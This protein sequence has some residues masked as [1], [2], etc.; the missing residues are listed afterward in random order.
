MISEKRRLLLLA[1][2]SVVACLMV[3]TIII[4]MTYRADV[5]QTFLRLQDTVTSQAR[6]IEAVARYDIEHRRGREPADQTL[7]QVIDAFRNFTGLGDTGEFALARRV[8]NQIV[9][10]YQQRVGASQSPTSI[11]MDA[12][13]AEPMRRALQGKSGT[14]IAVDYRGEMVLAAFEPVGVLHLGLV[15][16]IDRDEIRGAY[17]PAALSAVSIAALVGML[18]IV[19]FL[20]L[21]EPIVKLLLGQKAGLEAIVR[22]HE[23][24]AKRLGHSEAQQ[25]AIAQ[26]GA[27]AL[28]GA[29]IDELF[30]E[31]LSL[32][33]DVLGLAFAS[34][35][36][37]QP[38]K[39]TLL[40]RAGIGWKSGSVGR[41]TV[42]VNGDSQ[43]AHTL[44]PPVSASAGDLLQ[45]N[46]FAASPLMA[47]H[48]L[49]STAS[50]TI[51]G[52]DGPWGVFAVYGKQAGDF[53]EMDVLFVQSLANLLASAINRLRFD[54]DL[55][56]WVVLFHQA[57][58]GIA[59]TNAAGD[60]LTAVNPAFAKMHGY[61]MAEALQVPTR[62]YY[63]DGVELI[64][65]KITQH[66]GGGTVESMRARKDGSVFPAL[67]NVTTVYDDQGSV[68][69][70]V[71][72]V[73]DN[74]ERKQ[75]EES[76]L[77]LER[78]AQNA[79]RFESLG[80]LAGGI[81]HDFNNILMTILGN[82]DLALLDL[83]PQAPV[84]TSIEA[85]ETAA[86]QAV[87]LARQMLAYSGR[88][89]FVVQNIAINSLL[90]ETAHLLEA[91]VSQGIVLKY[92]LGDNLP[93]ISADATQMNQILMNLIINAS[94]AI[95]DKPGV[96][97]VTTG[98]LQCDREYLNSVAM[99][100]QVGI[101][102]ALAEGPYTWI[103]VSDTGCGMSVATLK[104]IFDPFFTTKGAG[105]G[106]G[107]AAI[108]GIVRAHKGA[109][110]VDSEVGK[111]SSVKV[112][113]PA[114]S[115]PAV[116]ADQTAGKVTCTGQ[117][118]ADGTVLLA[119]DDES[120]VALG[121][122]TLKRLG[123]DTI[124]VSDG[125]SAVEAFREHAT[126]ID[127]VI[128]DLTMPQMNGAEAFRE[129]RRIN[130]DAK[131]IL[132]SGYDEVEVTRKFAGEGLN[133]FLHK[134][135]TLDDL[136]RTLLAALD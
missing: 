41:A 68:L 70:Q 30:T 72:N 82:T 134:P 20:R 104:R 23:R 69:C 109:V 2:I 105:R 101:D 135:Y 121:Q 95:G 24:T 13:W 129:I 35:L 122:R 86:R 18:S 116:V 97:Q 132:C 39:Q 53:G 91:S 11:A 127:C 93:P 96:I 118:P 71:A 107:M 92:S 131:V 126:E 76:R 38:D 44:R 113:L 67:Q 81:A 15:A 85:I 110:K 108:L 47:E 124:A 17:I 56:H 77:E 106:L 45:E 84:R 54:E 123:F 29:S 27:L 28:R 63:Q 65:V 120:I 7:G 125:A 79:H 26:L 5:A 33:A 80:V 133:G 50:A 90:D 48:G 59:I 14:I 83:P 36:E 58:W 6:L 19:L 52:N 94:E 64:P 60:A 73:Q 117:L 16:K 9:F 43:L 57:A 42:P 25:R 62:N 102:E 21:S 98:V 88:G 40:L 31:A 61:T 100:A 55:R 51:G 37:L 3:A 114:N 128:L 32:V 103:E 8:D 78:Q 75:L 99:D 111:G 34:V 119:D 130:P 115:R 89:Q 74:S 46:Q 12:K 4:S 10:L 112:L 49:Q 87:G 136:K 1:S 22:E 66:P